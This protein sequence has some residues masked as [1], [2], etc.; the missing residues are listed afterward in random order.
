MSESPEFVVIFS[1]VP[2]QEVGGNIARELVRERL[3][4]CVNLVPGLTSIYEWKG[5][6]EEESEVLL[7]VKTTHG[8]AEPAIKR[9]IELHPY[10]VPEAIVLPILDGH[11]AYLDWI[12]SETSLPPLKEGSQP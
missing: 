1:T 2:S 6:L 3:A 12:Q 9:I 11:P 5:K 7:I 8:K 10:E 4:A